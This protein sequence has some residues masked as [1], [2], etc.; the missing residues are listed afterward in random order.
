VGEHGV[1][2]HLRIL[3]LVPHEGR[4]VR[5]RV[6]LQANTAFA[7]VELPTEVPRLAIEI[8]L[9]FRANIRQGQA[10]RVERPYV[11]RSTCQAFMALD[12]IGAS[13]SGS[14]AHTGASSF[15]VANP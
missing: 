7:F 13:L 1:L 8:C 11:V 14:S 6:L 5:R 3:G 4:E 12:V 9:A 15:G 2:R 10:Y